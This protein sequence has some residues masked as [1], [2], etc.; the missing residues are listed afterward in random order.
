MSPGMPVKANI[1]ELLHQWSSGKTEVAEELLP[2]IYD[3]LHRRAAASAQGEPRKNQSDE[4]AQP[5]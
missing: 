1:T 5:L 4:R 2:L 3:E